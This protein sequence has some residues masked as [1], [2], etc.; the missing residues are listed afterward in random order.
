[1]SKRKLVIIG[2]GMA[3]GRLVEDLLQRKLHERFKI[4]VFGEERHGCYNRILIADLLGGAEP[5]QITLR[6]PGWCA[7]QGVAFEPG[8]VVDRLDTAAKQVRLADGR[9]TDY[10]VA[11]LA[12]GSRAFVPPLPGVTTAAGRLTPGV[13]VFRTIE[14]CVTARAAARPG[15]KAAVV[16]GGLLGLEAARAL[17]ELG[18][19]VTLVERN[20]HLLNVQLDDAGGELVNAA[21]EKMGITLLKKAW[22]K[23]VLGG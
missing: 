15:A 5:G 23:R 1:V 18:M 13:F 22:T 19:A 8:V 4:T 21:F 20:D 11:V 14:D 2:N 16:G 17:K 3:G 7:T 12:T 9:T 10:D 6:Q